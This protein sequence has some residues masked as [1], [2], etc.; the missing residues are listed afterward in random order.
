MQTDSRALLCDF[1]WKLENDIN[2]GAPGVEK[3]K[4]T[5]SCRAV[6][7]SVVFYLGDG[8]LVPLQSVFASF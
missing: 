4:E 2:F 8:I 5:P 7:F 1:V 3:K 6:S